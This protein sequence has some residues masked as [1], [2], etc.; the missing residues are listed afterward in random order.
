MAFE[1][2]ILQK[3]WN[4]FEI[5][6]SSKSKVITEKQKKKRRKQKEQ[7]KKE[8]TD[9]PA[10]LGRIGPVTPRATR[11]SAQP[12]AAV[13]RRS[14]TGGAHLSVVFKLRPRI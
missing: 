8:E 6:W 10:N 12:A 5:I 1:D 2:M 14:P 11:E 9:R 13:R 4:L 7:K 3:N